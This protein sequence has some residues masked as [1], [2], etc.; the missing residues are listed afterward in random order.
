[1]TIMVAF[2]QRLL[3]RY[4]RVADRP[5]YPVLNVGLAFAATLLAIAFVPILLALVALKPRHWLRTAIWC[6]VGSALGASLM[7]WLVGEYGPQAVAELLPSIARSREW[8]T[9]LRWVEQFGFV[10]VIAVAGLPLSQTPVLIVCALL[11]MPLKEVFA[12]VLL[13]KLVKYTVSAAL[14][15]T[16]LNQV[17]TREQDGTGAD[18]SHK[19]ES[20]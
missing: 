16:A 15:T 3:A 11:G 12:S 17:S 13:G 20:T 7:A 1:M 8:V 4:S 14:A 5:V 6:A 2:I 9:G 19:T 10:A 18:K